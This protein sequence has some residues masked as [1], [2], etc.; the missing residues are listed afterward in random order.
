[1]VPRM[2]DEFPVFTLAAA[3]AEGRSEV[4][5][6]KE[7]RYKESDRIASIAR[8]MLR[9]GIHVEQQEDG[10]TV[11]GGQKP[12]AAAASSEGDHRI[13]MTLAVAGLLAEGATTVEDTGCVA[14]SFPNFF[15]LL[16]QCGGEAQ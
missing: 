4:R 13:A 5:Q 9:L 7:L 1:M 16:N 3:C 10:Y 11:E 14:T 8:Q 6:A 15:Q 12:K 2:I